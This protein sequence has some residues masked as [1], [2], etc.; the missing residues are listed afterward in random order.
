M[1]PMRYG[2][3]LLEEILRRTDIVQLVGSKVL[4]ALRQAVSD[5]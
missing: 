4:H 2:P 1:G 3:N 5:R